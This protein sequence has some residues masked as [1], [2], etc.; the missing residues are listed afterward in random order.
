MKKGL[1]A[2]ACGGMAI[3]MTEFTMMGIL[4]DIAQDLNI[5]IPRAAH[6]IALYALGVVV[7]AP[8][9]VLMTSKYPPKTVLL[10]FM[11]MFVI[12]NGLF[13]IAPNMWT[14]EVSRFASGLP[15]GAFF[16]VGSV[17]ATN[18]AT[19]GKEAQ[20][21]AIMFTGMTL[22]NLIGVPIGTYVG[23]H[24]SW[25]LTY[26]IISLLGL[27]TFLAILFWLPKVNTSSNQNLFAQLNY[28]KTWRAWLL[29]A[30][31]SIG[32]GGLFAWISYIA[33]LVT[34]VGGVQKDRVPLIMI[35]VGL[36]M[37]FGN[38][39][40]GKLADSINP[41]KATMISFGSMII[42]LIIVHFTA[43]INTM[44]YVMAFFTGLV[45]FTVGSPLQ[46]MLIQSAKGAETMAASAGQASFNLG[47][48]LGAYFGGLPITYGLAFDTPVLVGAGMAFIGVLLTFSYLKCQ[49][50]IH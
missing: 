23:H 3:G 16:G 46:M 24:F 25:R 1:V 42:C 50:N 38:L 31:I 6:L 27:V 9:L 43:H 5:D 37:F 33:P 41:T 39:L 8:T 14:L 21:I 29:V 12:F 47:N 2:L 19:K 7:G 34:E 4:P 13:A 28:F 36:G 17:V 18:L 22:A 26:G 48:T 45:S 10:A 15:H 11:V 40:G 44:A 20:A 30:L 35:L 49:K 32:T